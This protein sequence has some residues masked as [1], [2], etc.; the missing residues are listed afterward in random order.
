MVYLDF[1]VLN[2]HDG[3]IDYRVPRMLHVKNADFNLLE[4]LDRKRSSRKSYG[5][6]QVHIFSV[7]L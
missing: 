4:R 5:M 6:L 7:Y 1:C 3:D 2:G